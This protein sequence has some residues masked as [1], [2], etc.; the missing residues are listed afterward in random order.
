MM[1][2]MMYQKYETCYEKIGYNAIEKLLQ[3]KKLWPTD[4]IQSVCK[5][6]RSYV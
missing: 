4:Q 6:Q 5:K 1:M 3:T 2:M